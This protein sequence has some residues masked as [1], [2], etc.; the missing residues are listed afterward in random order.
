[1]AKCPLCGGLNDPA[2]TTVLVFSFFPFS[3]GQGYATMVGRRMGPTKVPTQY[4]RPRL[5]A[6]PAAVHPRDHQEG[7]LSN[8]S[9]GLVGEVEAI[10][11]SEISTA[12][13][14]Y[15]WTVVQLVVL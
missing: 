12:I 13:E 4:N 2:S 1:M 8:G 14:M 3:A 6:A 7:I 15:S 11:K 5:A 10:D 9:I